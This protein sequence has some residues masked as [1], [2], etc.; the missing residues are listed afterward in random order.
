MAE[1]QITVYNQGKL[2]LLT[3][4]M[5]GATLKVALVTGYTIDIDSHSYW[6]DISSNEE[7]GTGYTAG[8]ETLGSVT[9]TKDNTN[10]VATM[11]AADVQWT[12]LDVGTP[13]HAICYISTG[14]D[15]TSQLLFAVEIGTTTNGSNYNLVWNASGI[16]QLS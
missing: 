11:D 6:S 1:G 2:A 12:A 15:S 16:L 3:T 4:A 9:Y 13:S 7:S 14:T 10:D 5:S 8:G